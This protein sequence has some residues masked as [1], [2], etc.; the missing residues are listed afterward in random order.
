MERT[1]LH[2]DIN[3]C[4]ASIECLHNPSLCGRPV[5]VGGNAQERHGIILAKNYQAKDFGVAV[6]QTLWEAKEKCPELVILPPNYDLYFKYSGYIR[7]IFNMYTDM[8]EPFGIDE[9]WLDVSDSRLLFGGGSEIAEEIRSRVKRELGVTVSI[10][11]SFNKV[12]AKLGSDM[13]KP[14][15]ITVLSRNNYKQLAWPLPVENL[16]YVGSA[17]KTKLYSKGIRDRKS[18]V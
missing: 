5:A 9:A 16:L 3:N 14:D 7:E 6:G 4:Y 12:F 11:I 18:V 13:K 15:A 8:V 17:T 10:G 2:V 1:I